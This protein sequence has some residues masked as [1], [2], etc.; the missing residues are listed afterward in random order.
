MLNLAKSHAGISSIIQS[1][2]D[3]DWK[4]SK[5]H[6]ILCGSSMSFTEKQVEEKQYIELKMAV[7][8]FIIGMF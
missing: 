6:I 2:C 8:D 1:M 7:L 3:H 5:L 4:Q